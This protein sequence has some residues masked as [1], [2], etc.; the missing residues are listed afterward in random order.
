MNYLD[1]W[2]LCLLHD[3]QVI[4]LARCCQYRGFWQNL[5][6]SM[7]YSVIGSDYGVAFPAHHC[8]KF[9]QLI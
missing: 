4:Y 2:E 5:A 9:R 7:A 3:I 1:R 8:L 6:Q